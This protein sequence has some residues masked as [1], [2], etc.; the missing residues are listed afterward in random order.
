MEYG[1]EGD[2]VVELE[3]VSASELSRSV[4]LRAADDMYADVE[5]VSGNR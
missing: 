4:V 3:I 1:S 5:H 2:L